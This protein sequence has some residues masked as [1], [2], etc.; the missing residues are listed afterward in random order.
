MSDIMDGT[1]YRY[2]KEFMKDTTTLPLVCRLFVIINDY[3]INHYNEYADPKDTI[4]AN[5]LAF[6]SLLKLLV[7]ETTLTEVR[8]AGRHDPD[9]DNPNE[10]AD[11]LFYEELFGIFA[12]ALFCSSKTAMLDLGNSMFKHDLKKTFD[13]ICVLPDSIGAIM[14][15]DAGDIV[16][17]SG[18]L[19][20][21]HEGRALAHLTRDV[22]QLVSIVQPE[23][24]TI[25]RV[26]VS[27]QSGVSIV[28]T[29]HQGHVFGV[30]LAHR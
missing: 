8:R 25:T 18:S 12:N 4:I 2:F 5:V 23:T 7:P 19:R 6:A 11:G 21:V 24:K 26:T 17:A 16:R 3:E 28:A 15:T 14:V 1:S 22:A 27:R 30:K 9:D 13:N 29:P 10:E 20:E